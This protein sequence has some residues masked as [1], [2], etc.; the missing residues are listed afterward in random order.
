M[1]HQQ[2]GQALL[3][4]AGDAMLTE[5]FAAADSLDAKVSFLKEQ[6]FDVD[7]S[8]FVGF[9]QVVAEAKANEHSD[10]LSDQELAAAQGGFFVDILASSVGLG[11][12]IYF[13]SVPGASLGMAV[14]SRLGAVI[15]AVI[16]SV[17]KSETYDQLN[18]TFSV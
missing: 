6:G 4:V 2:F 5:S 13:G 8:D 12:G 1:S 17:A 18:Q 7:Y 11:L 10:E 16:G 14:G 3:K 15:D 9:A